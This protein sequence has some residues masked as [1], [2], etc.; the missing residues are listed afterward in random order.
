M[1]V[2]TSVLIMVRSIG[3]CVQFTTISVR[4]TCIWAKGVAC[5]RRRGWHS[6]NIVL[7]LPK[8]VL[9]FFQFLCKIFYL[10]S[11]GFTKSLELFLQCVLQGYLLV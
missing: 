10:M 6:I 2:L 11:V 7:E 8:L 3:V 4:D 1:A 5:I 9:S